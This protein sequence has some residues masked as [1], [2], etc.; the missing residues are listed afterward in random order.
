MRFLQRDESGKLVGHYANPQPYA[1]EAVAD[2][3]PDIVAWNTARK[4]DQAD[5]LARKARLDPEKLLERIEELEA[6]L[7]K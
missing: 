6:R 3:H 7:G 2:D 1:Q 5:Y 4:K